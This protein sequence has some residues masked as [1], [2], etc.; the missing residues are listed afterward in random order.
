[1][2]TPEYKTC[3]RCGE[4]KPLSEY[5]KDRGKP[6]AQCKDCKKATIYATRNAD[7]EAHRAYQRQW[8]AENSDARN[9]KVRERRERD[10]D[11]LRTKDR[12]RWARDRE[13]RSEQRREWYIANREHVRERQAWANNPGV[14]ASHLKYREANRDKILEQARTA[15]YKRRA[16]MTELYVED[17]PLDDVLL[18][19]LGICGI[20]D[21]PIL[22]STV[23]LDHIIPLAAGGRHERTNIQ[24]AHRSCN[25]RKFTKLDF[26]L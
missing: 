6:V 16:L 21:N 17:V 25:R 23:E 13:K 10:G 8:H 11:Y 9:A 15:R 2:P 26:S 14:K 7:R 4:T 22:E 3:S 18:R 5:Y 24:L 19:D 20:C 12:A 1:V